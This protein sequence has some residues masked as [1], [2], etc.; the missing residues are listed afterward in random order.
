MKL[1]YT[2]L[3]LALFLFLFQ[4]GNSEATDHTYLA[5]NSTL[6][7]TGVTGTDNSHFY[8]P[9]G[10]AV[11]SSGNL[12]VADQSNH[13]IQKFNSAG[14]YNSTLGVTGVTGTDNSH[15]NSPTGVAVDSSGNL[16]IADQNNHRIQK[17]NSAGIYQST[18]GESGNSGSDNSH[19]QNPTGVAVDSSG[20][21]YVAD[22]NNQRVQKFNSSGVYQST[23]G[24][25]GVVGFNNSYFNYPTG[26]AVDSSGNLYVAD[27]NNNRI[28]KFN[29]AGIYQSTL[30]V[31]GVSGSDNSHFYFPYGVAVDSSDNLHVADQFNHR[32]QKFNSAGIYQSTIGESG[33]SGTDNSH[34]SYPAG[35]TVDSSGNIY[36]ADASNARVQKFSLT[37]DDAPPII[38]ITSPVNQ[39][40]V[41]PTF[42]IKGIALDAESGVN[43]VTIKI[44][45]GPVSNVTNT[46]S[47]FSMWI[48]IAHNLSNGLHT[49][50]ANATDNVGNL[51]QTKII[52]TVS[53]SHLYLGSAST[54]GV[55][56]VTGTDNSHFNYPTG[57]AVDSSGNLYV[58]DQY[59]DRIQIFNSAGVYNSSLG[60]SGVF[61]SDNSH[62]DTPSDVAVDSSGNRYVA[63]LYNDRIQKFNSA[64]VYNSTIGAGFGSDNSHFDTPSGIAVDSSGNL[65][66]ADQD[67]HRI[68]KFNS[69]GVYQS[70]LGVTGVTGTDNSHFDSPFGV[71]V[72]SSGNIYVSDANNDRIQKFNSAGIYQ[73]T[74]GV[75]GISGTDNSHFHYPSGVAVD[76]SGNLY[77]ADLYNGRIQKFNSAGVYHS[78]IGEGY[79]TDN[80][81]FQNPTGVAVDSSGNIY[82]ADRFNHRVQIF[83]MSEDDTLPTLS[84][85]YP[86]NQTLVAS[87][88][89]ILGTASDIGSGIN[90]VTVK[91]DNGP[92]STAG[93]TGTAFSTW[94]FAANNLSLGSHTIYANVT[95]ITGNINSTMTIVTVSSS[96]LYMGNSLTLGETGVS[97][98][99]NSH[100]A[101]TQG[102]A[103][104]SSGNLYIADFYNSRIQKFNSIG[105]YLLTLG[106]SG[107]SGSDNSHLANPEDVAVDSSG[108]I[109]VADYNNQR[110]QIFN[111]TGIYN[112]TLGVTGV[113]GTDNSHFHSPTGVA[114]DSSGNLYV[115]D[116]GN[117]RIQKFNSA[118]VYQSTLGVTGVTGTDNS[119]FNSPFG[120]TVDSSG[121]LYVA[122]YNNHR[123]QKFNSAGVYQST[124]GESGV[125]GSDN[126]HFIY[127]AGVAVDSSG[128]IYVADSSNARVQI[129]NSAGVYNSTLG[130]T[131]V[132]GT[133][134]FHFD[135]P[136]DV[137]VDSSGNIYVSDADNYRI[138]KFSLLVDNAPPTVSITYPTN[139]QLFATPTV[140]VTGT[141]ADTESGIQK[142]EVSVDGGAYSLADGTT[143]WSFTKHQLSNGVHT[144]NAKAT[145]VVGS[146]A[147][148][149][150]PFTI[151]LTT[152][153]LYGITAGESSTADFYHLFDGTG[154]DDFIGNTGE[155]L[156]GIVFGSDGTLYTYGDD[157]FGTIDP[158]TAA[159]TP[160]GNSASIGKCT[161]IAIDPVDKVFYCQQ[162]NTLYSINKTNG[163]TT[164]VGHTGVSQNKGSAMSIA[165]DG[166]MYYGNQV[167]L[168]SEDK[169]NGHATLI[170]NWILPPEIVDSNCRTN[171]FDFDSSGT[172]GASLNCNSNNYLV[173]VNTGTAQLTFVGTTVSLLDGIAFIPP[174]PPTVSITYPINGTT[175]NTSSITITG[176]ASDLGPGLQKVEVSVD[177]GTYS[178]ADGTTSWSFIVT[179]LANGDHTVIAKVTDN[180]GNVGFSYDTNSVVGSPISVG[181]T[182]RGIVFDSANGNLYV[183]N[184]SSGTVSVINGTTNTI[185]GSQIHVGATPFGIAF[186]SANGNLYVTKQGSNTVSVINGTTNTIIGSPISVGN[187][188]LGIAF[189][190]ANGNLYVTNSGSNDVYVINGTTNTIIGS[191]ISVGTS[192]WGI[193]FDS[194]NGNLYVT[195]FSSAT[196]SVINGTTNTIIGSPISV[197][198][199]P[200]GIAFDSAN[201]NLYVTNSD[202]NTVSVINGTTNTIIGS[203]ISVGSNP[204][205]I[206]FD[207]ANGNLYVVNNGA[208][209]VSVINGT[210]NTIIGSQIPIGTNPWVIAFD[211]A[212]G[213]LYVANSGSDTVSVISTPT[214]FTV[215]ET[216]SP[217]FIL[218]GT[219]SVNA[220]QG[221]LGASNVVLNSIDGFSDNV[222]LALQS[223]PSGVSGTFARNQL[224]MTS[225]FN[226]TGFTLY[227]APTVLPGTYSFVVNATSGLISHTITMPLYVFSQADVT[228]SATS[229]ILYGTDA[230]SHH[231]LTISKS[232]GHGT[233]M[234]SFGDGSY[235]ALAID[236]TTGMMYLGQSGGTPYL[237]R[238]NPSNGAK[239]FVGDTGLGFAAIADMSFRQD[240]TLFA[241]VNTAGD[242]GSGADHLVTINKISGIA[243]VV[244]PFG[245]CTGVFIPSSAEGSC[246]LEGIE[247][248]AFNS[249]GTLYGSSSSRGGLQIPALYMLNTATGAATQ[250]VHIL[251]STGHPPSGGVVSLTFSGSTLYGGTSR[252][253]N[254]TDSGYLITINPATGLFTKIGKTTTSSLGALALFSTPPSFSKSLSNSI[255]IHDSLLAKKTG[256]GPS[257]TNLVA[258][259]QTGINTGYGNGLIITATF[260]EGTNKP[261]GTAIQNKTSVDKIF[262][263]SQNLGANYTGK[264]RDTANFVITIRNS[265][266]ATPPAIGV[267]TFTVK[268]S[269]NLQNLAGTSNPSVSQSPHLTGSFTSRPGPFITA[270]VVN[271]PSGIHPTYSN[272]DTI[273]IRFSEPTNRPLGTG[274]LNKGDVDSLFTFTE[275][276]GNAYTGHWADASNFVITIVDSTG[277]TPPDIGVTT[278][279]VNAPAN[280]KNSI[281][282]SLSSTST[283]PTLSGHFGNRPGPFITD[284]VASDPTGT[285]GTYSNGITIT[286][287]FSEP[288]NTFDPT[289]LVPGLSKSDLSSMFVFSQ[290]LG[291][292][293]AG[294]WVDQST[295]V[296]T[297]T[298]A[299]NSTPPAIGV[300]TAT[301]IGN[302]RDAS[303]TSAPSTS[304]SPFLS[305]SFGNRTGPS[306]TS[307]IAS[308][309]DVSDAV[310]SNGDT[311]TVTFSETTNRPGGTG[312]FDKHAVDDLFTFSQTLGTN[313]NA[314]SGQWVDPSHFVITIIDSTGSTPP[315]IGVLT[316]TVNSP[317]NLKN[318]AGTS[319]ASVSISPLLT[320][321]FGDRPGP[322]ITSLVASD[323]TGTHGT[324]SNGITITARFSEST[325]QPGGTAIQNKTSVDKIFTFSQNLGNNY[326]GQWVD[327]STF[328][329]TILDSTGSQPPTIGGLTATIKASANLKNA[330][331]ISLPSTST[332]PLLSGSYG[333]RQGPF[334]TNLIADDP[335]ETHNS[336]TSDITVTAV[337]S[338]STNK[339]GGIAVQNKNNVDN[340][341]TFS[342]SL[343]ANYTGQWVTSSTFVITIKDSTGATPPAIGVF[344]ATV[345]PS[346][347][348]KNTGG[349]SLPS[350]STSPLLAGTFGTFTVSIPVTDGGSAV[351]TLP[352]GITT[353]ITLPSGSEGTIDITKSNGTTT[354]TTNGTTINFLGN[355]ANI[356][357][358]GGASCSAEC[359][360]SFTFTQADADVFHIKPLNV[361]IYHDANEDGVF[362]SNEALPTVVTKTGAERFI[363]TAHVSFNSK[364]A[365]GGIV[366][367]LA[368]L[369]ALGGGGGYSAPAFSG[370]AFAADEFPLSIDGKNFKLDH[371]SNTIPTITLQTGQSVKLNLA[372]Y[373]S[374]GSQYLQHVALYTNLRGSNIDVYHSDTSITYEK[375]QSVQVT[376][377]NGMFSSTSVSTSE[378][379]NKLVVS[380]DIV[381]AKPM[382]KSDIIIRSWDLN[383]DTTDTTILDA[384]QVEGN[385]IAPPP[386][387]NTLAN[388]P[389]AKQTQIPE[390]LN[391]PYWVKNN[392]N[393]WSSG[394]IGDSDFT[395][396]IQYLIQQ[397]IMIIPKTTAGSTQSQQ[398]P[399]WVKNNAGWWAS[400]QITDNDFVK[401]IQYLITGGIIKISG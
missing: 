263:F 35:V 170:H 305:G 217:D 281:G 89:T 219:R 257:I 121:N 122:D 350:I 326:K 49:I 270:L 145:D 188:P 162:K 222:T 381:F 105:V 150:V 204:F 131:L 45:N 26:V 8:Y 342:Q 136:T 214:F 34:F 221:N 297:I 202:S 258:L 14:V 88:F 164:L 103:V 224:D 85:T 355:I 288:T 96:H 157:G 79:G 323:P 95:D 239:T 370:S 58:A 249:T 6:G 313:P 229:G 9:S 47:V 278:A 65:Y 213:N 336:Y 134:R 69:A 129:F 21:L 12:Y 280:L 161:D 255:T 30:G 251:N 295:L 300:L 113:T 10:V 40:S 364:F 387:P 165:S 218:L 371:S 68:Q 401:G 76:S 252:S 23:L 398:I 335:T 91:I 303:G 130:E 314:Y 42:A 168:Y 115:A 153:A 400:D 225:G 294:L 354:Q 53:S 329:I 296:I 348:L 232:T 109:Y 376:D 151:S 234:G 191:P 344:S 180:A 43:T 369:A 289:P 190:S 347:N 116:F 382:K 262:T 312:I 155:Y 193:A 240:G 148:T 228:P 360:I 176:T 84:I 54:L 247:G 32:I 226:E 210:T 7:V 207:S 104:D 298:D 149:T 378:V 156:S 337:F 393:W 380:F 269:A 308:D 285:H 399:S 322:F 362:E 110:V 271:D 391:I 261:G 286:V 392:A 55:T 244:G 386:A 77:V 51:N 198:S 138:Q 177:N 211:S 215:A 167:G 306:I 250:I 307:L 265:T 64:G 39:T 73:L 388:L 384:I 169:T 52:V 200:I 199:L 144:I 141:A 101:V 41:A 277:S 15:F 5:Y 83:L 248:I 216:T 206:A 99:D 19:F 94:A 197:G 132:S 31:S 309:P 196:V 235:S 304:T 243:T 186:D 111:S 273:T 119:H 242:G 230:S 253:G 140:T 324:Y 319:S 137:A 203:P 365:I 320:G 114:V 81:H 22:Y 311:L 98:T 152:D 201:G 284:L 61:G 373:E 321:S 299:T 158:N 62:F 194:A 178:L 173:T 38:S 292:N 163:Q 86:A 135:S 29:S 205:G 330:P 259:D 154:I 59:N 208:N 290:N 346:A 343:G 171:A 287:R 166:T 189:D 87:S 160:I 301:V 67:N 338:E 60:V 279:T 372:I 128:N 241:A 2:L 123:I 394:K 352:S 182:P 117:T 260:S 66:V 349:T 146:T 126:S 159:F 56:G 356:T 395:K 358:Q 24:V 36:V 147:V 125:Y 28:Q 37:V 92:V 274:L 71:T 390:S 80:S 25:T 192:P 107:H 3:F 359:V 317:A 185:I 375:G 374:A 174:T 11:D 333:T 345:N 254:A 397:K 112:S 267:L 124:L 275:N 172:L 48:F 93:N 57:V 102:I 90:T 118:H 175:I 377:P 340:I 108:N 227:L 331:A 363:A 237:Y 268:A 357:P 325:N 209:T 353:T 184:L 106:V 120:V 27:Q 16:Y 97:G 127:P 223:L 245:S 283:S 318:L 82:V 366:P 50:Y 75:T 139:T 256:P 74:L 70:T 18:I 361:K 351:V 339:P 276:L 282:T 143:S 383:L 293:Y 212:N 272:G 1:Q 72:D 142:V 133:D 367:A 379:N 220:T 63:D 264:W 179:D 266:G 389:K 78:T 183:S 181:T 315:A 327:P 13:R 187:N 328:I 246:T 44:D 334:I 46:E 396:G 385:S 302:I 17:F 341:F 291:D 368:I 316:A 238:V 310:Y 100:F 20:N 332:S 236:P 231:L 233:I 4:Y 33:V 195:N